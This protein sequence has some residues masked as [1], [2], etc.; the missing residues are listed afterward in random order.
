MIIQ[1]KGELHGI[2]F[3]VNYDT[4]DDDGTVVAVQEERNAGLITW[5]EAGYCLD[6]VNRAR[7]RWRKMLQEGNKENA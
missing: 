5:R 4:D 7:A 2:R 6:L 3:L 1:E